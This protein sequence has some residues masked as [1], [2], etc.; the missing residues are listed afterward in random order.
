MNKQQMDANIAQARVVLQRAEAVIITAGAGMGVDSG[1]P[2]FRGDDGL[3]NAYPAL[4]GMRLKFQDI[5]NPKWFIQHPELAWAFYGHRLHL[6]H[7][8]EPHIGFDLL[9]EYINRKNDNYFVITSNVDGGFQKAG[10]D[11]QKIREKHG[12]IRSLQ[13][14]YGCKGDVWLV[15]YSEI[16]VDEERFVATKMP[17][18]PHCGKVARPNILMFDDFGWLSKVER[19]HQHKFGLWFARMKRNNERFVIIEIGAGTTVP[20]IRRLSETLATHSHADLI[21][22]NP[23]EDGVPMGAISIRTGG[24]D[25][26]NML[27]GNQPKI[28]IW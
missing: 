26:L 19:R 1:L 13:C 23:R 2:D 9:R 7:K 27:L 12:A 20:S 8:T 14:V 6:Y 24:R 17:T 15:D 5:A 4:H 18:C 28:T 3:W 16:V 21:R 11:P 25:G 22:I 10:F